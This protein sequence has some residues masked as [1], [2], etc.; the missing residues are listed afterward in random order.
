M[1]RF[2]PD[3]WGGDPFRALR[4]EMNELMGD[5]GRRLPSMPMDVGQTPPMNVAET[6]EAI[7]IS[8]DLPGL[9]EKDVSVTLDGNRLVVSGEHREE[10]ES[11]EKDWRVV[12][13]R[14]GSFYRAVMLPFEP[15]EEAIEA[16]FEKGVLKLS[17]RKPAETLAGARRIS[18]GAGPKPPAAETATNENAEAAQ[19][20][21]PRSGHA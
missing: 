9:D 16:H 21:A 19:G 20:D 14:S 11:A 15:R 2:L 3:L 17:V 6:K 5:F 13:R 10:S 1:T 12:E 8:M 4:R 7:E 18:I